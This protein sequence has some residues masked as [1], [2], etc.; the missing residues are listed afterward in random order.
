M[1]PW[2]CE[3]RHAGAAHDTASTRHRGIAPNACVP[4]PLAGALRSSACSG[5]ALPASVGVACGAS[6]LLATSCLSCERCVWSAVALARANPMKTRTVTRPNLLSFGRENGIRLP[7]PVK[8]KSQSMG[9]YC[10][11]SCYFMPRVSHARELPISCSSETCSA[12]QAVEPRQS[13][14]TS[15]PSHL[16]QMQATPTAQ[17]RAMRAAVAALQELGSTRTPTGCLIFGPADAPSFLKSAH[18]G[19]AT[20]PSCNEQ[21]VHASR[22]GVAC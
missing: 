15:F 22:S 12:E 19:R 13:R 2:P 16:R 14:R 7:Q 6:P 18:P 1:H 8:A 5:I 11:R 20:R 10:G 4:W 9:M 21:R 3:A 17:A